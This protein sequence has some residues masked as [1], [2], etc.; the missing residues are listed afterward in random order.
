MNTI[1]N[2]KLS[3]L[4]VSPQNVRVASAKNRK[5]KREPRAFAPRAFC[6]TLW[7]FQVKIKKPTLK[8]TPIQI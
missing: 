5:T 8:Q 6:K 1:Q 2:I 3:D 4:M 7:T